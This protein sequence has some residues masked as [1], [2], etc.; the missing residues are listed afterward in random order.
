[1]N[2]LDKIVMN[3]SVSLILLL[4]IFFY[5]PESFGH[6]LYLNEIM[7]SNATTIEDEDGDAEDW[8]EIY[9]SGS[10]P[11]NLE[12]YGLSDDYDRPFRWIFPDVIIEPGEFM[13]IWASGKDRNNPDYPLHTNFRIASAG[14]EVLLT[15]SD[16]TRID[17]LAPTAI[18]TDISL[19]RKPDG[20][21]EW[22][23]F[24]EPTPG[25]PNDTEGYQELL[26]PVEFS[27][28][29]GFY[30]N[31][32]ELILSPPDPDVTIIYTM[33]GSE[34]DPANIGGQTYQYKDRY[35]RNPS[36]TDGSL[37]DA[38]YES[39]EYSDP[40]TITDRTEKP[41]RISRIHTTIDNA[42][43][44][45]Y[46]PSHSIF[47]GTVIRARAVKTGALQSKEKT[48]TYFVTPEMR[49]WYTLPVV[50][51]AMQE[52]YLF[53]YETGIYVPGIIYDDWRSS[54]DDGAGGFS[55]ANYHQRGYEWEH[56]AHMELFE[57]GMTEA[58]LKQRM[59]VRI[60]GGISRS[61]RMKSLRLYARNQYGDNRFY[62]RIFPDLP[63]TE[64]NRLILR[65]SGNDFDLTLF[66]DAAIQEVVKHMNFDVQ[67]YRPAIVF[68][69][70][71]YWGIHNFRERYDRHYLSRVYDVEDDRVDILEGNAWVKEGSDVHYNETI[72][73]I[74]T[75]GLSADEHYEYIKTRIDVEN[76][77]DYQVAQIYVGNGDWPGNNIDF[78]RYQTDTYDPD[79][80]YG[81]DGRWR[82]LM[83]DTDFGFG[84][85]DIHPPSD[86]MLEFATRTDGPDWPNP[87]WSTFLLR[88]F[89]ENETFRNNF[90]NRFADQINTAFRPERVHNIINNMA[91]MVEPEIAEQIERWKRPGWGWV[92]VWEN[93]VNVMRNFVN[94]R[95]QYMRGHIR[96]YFNIQSEV[97]LTV[98]VSDPSTG[99]VYVNSIEISPSTPG[100]DP[101]PY[102]WTG[103]Y[104]H[105]IPV[106]LKAKAYPGYKFSYW[107]GYDG[108]I[109]AAEI[110]LPMTEAA[111]LTAV[112]EKDDEA[113]LIPEPFKLADGVYVFEEW[114][115]DV[116]AGVYPNNMVFVYMNEMEPGLDAE[117]EDLTFG[118]YNLDSRTRI[119]G[120]EADGFAFI[121]TSNEEG[122]PG[123]PGRRL[124]GAILALNTQG[125][126]NIEVSWEGITVRP[127]SRVY[128]LRLQYRVGNDGKFQDVLDET[129]EPVEYRRHE[130]PGH[131]EHIGPVRLPPEVDNK[132]YVQLL[133]R[134][135]FTGTRVDEESGQRSKMAVSGI[136]VEGVDDPVTGIEAAEDIPVEYNL[137]QNYPNPFNPITHIRFALPEADTVK[138]T[139]YDILGREVVRLV[140]GHLNA[141][142]HT[143]KFDASELSGGMY[144][145]RIKTDEFVQSK[146]MLYVK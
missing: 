19:G 114:S 117:V 75:Y 70:G 35:R 47:K 92:S 15:A 127:N 81:K 54:S 58:S 123:Y 12:G 69:N 90:I 13:V 16:S 112:F 36:D 115:S 53:G 145:F 94:A 116:P 17:E 38:A 87:P 133:W 3:S 71:E 118:V 23:F 33:D 9:Y 56:P 68:I 86:N 84:L 122:N 110:E 8:I 80:P 99:C 101:E 79:A 119:N 135:Y 98:N 7:A 57:D 125:K 144:I 108:D 97:E 136:T 139:V 146:R 96:E 29:G 14:E 2:R 83:Y 100:I 21:G 131:R 120:L 5:T 132:A 37:A 46:F 142:L 103:I 63:Y 93:D 61:F 141:G 140:D 28:S 74:E 106:T 60:H 137:Y 48:N 88:S 10:E 1:M 72:N 126:K 82:W 67:A 49:D 89:L 76:F 105:N 55:P 143:V 20:T 59:G 78:W 50:S 26:D 113:D 134:Y 42:I 31:N 11:L 130:N 95:P 138:L 18:P 40:I 32:I 107:E 51:I 44:P 124:G 111:A 30:A 128:N 102:P 52:N 91:E 121:N 77:L 24:N 22:H 62:H 6:D 64:Y 109:N 45:E 73:Y 129:G 41:N 27:H 25:A 85:F 39:F 66:R 34:P 65:N 104:F 4:L 43:T